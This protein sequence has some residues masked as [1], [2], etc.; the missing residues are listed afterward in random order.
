M[1]KRLTTSLV[2]L[3]LLPLALTTACTAPP[4]PPDSPAASSPHKP[5]KD[6]ATPRQPIAPRS[7]ERIEPVWTKKLEPIGQ[8]VLRDGVALIITGEGQLMDLVALD[9]ESGK[10]LW[11]KDYHPGDVPSGIVNGPSIA[12]DDEGRTRAVF[13]E[14]NT[15]PEDDWGSYN[16][17]VAVA[18]DLKTGKEVYRGKSSEL[19]NNRPGE[20]DDGTDLCYRRWR[21]SDG[22][23]ELVRVDLA[24][25]RVRHG[26]EAGPLGGA[27]Q[28][29]GAG[30]LVAV[31][32]EPQQ[33]ARA[34]KDKVLWKKNMKSVFGSGATTSWGWSFD[35]LEKKNLFIGAVGIRPRPDL[36]DEKFNELD[37]YTI[38]A[39]DQMIAGI[40]AT[41]GKVRWRARG[42]HPWCRSNLGTSGTRF[43]DGKA[44]P[45]RCEF[46]SGSL[47]VPGNNKY[48]QAKARLVGYD[49]LTGKAAWKS[50][51]VEI[52]RIDELFTATAG[53]GDYVLTGG[54][55]G[56]MVIDTTSGHS[57]KAAAHETFFCTSRAFYNLPIEPDEDSPTHGSGGRLYMSCTATGKKA[58]G[59]TVGAVTDADNTEE[60]TTV[61][62]EEGRILGFRL[63]AGQES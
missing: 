34:D 35:Y 2:S 46:L 20:C 12:E 52:T 58:K 14:R 29:I 6:P 5:P 47:Q 63:P 41:T 15:I 9:V 3:A 61:V 17:T 23:L 53:R 49:P 45:V 22:T 43:Y 36:D 7:T 57:R 40:D 4:T 54:S 60:G 16:W 10:E 25:G 19:V 44:Y 8:P 30:G 31:W 56:N 18:V 37:S 24:T 38:D 39:T 13:L 51:P 62:A 21:L 28:P 48:R 50:K 32:G 27:A 11:R 55:G 33:I 26:K 1:G 42:S 59:Y